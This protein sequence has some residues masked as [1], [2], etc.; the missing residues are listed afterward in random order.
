MS[1]RDIIAVCQRHIYRHPND[2]AAFVKAVADTCGVL[3]AGDANAIAGMVKSGC[4]RSLPN[5]LSAK[6]AAANGELVIAGVQA[7]GHGHVVVIVDGPNRGKYPYAFWG[8][9]HGLTIDGVSQNIGFTRGHGTLNYAF[10]SPAL[11][12]VVFA[13][14]TPVATLLPE[15]APNEG[16]LIHTFS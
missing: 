12:A 3:L 11:D 15:L 13:A 10:K 5:G 2:C 8:Q 14:F 7:P 6:V 16:Y 4:G 9:Y 1:S